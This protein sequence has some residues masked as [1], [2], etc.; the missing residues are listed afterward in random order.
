M[1]SQYQHLIKEYL[2]HDEYVIWDGKPGKGHLLTEQDI[3]MLPF[4]IMW[5]LLSIICAALLAST[6]IVPKL[7]GIPFVCIGLYLFASQ[8]DIAG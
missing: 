4:D 6:D 2:V 8:Y 5:S 7:L 3:I 1:D